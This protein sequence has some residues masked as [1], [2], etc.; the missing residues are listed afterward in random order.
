M[1][2]ICFLLIIIDVLA[3]DHG[4]FLIQTKKGEAYLA[5]LGNPKAE[6]GKNKKSGYDYELR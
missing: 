5:E 4:T 1:W 2:A 6:K 3:R